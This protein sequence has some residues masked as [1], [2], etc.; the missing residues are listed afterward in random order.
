MIPVT[1]MLAYQWTVN[2]EKNTYLYLTGLSVVLAFIFKPLL[3]SIGFF[4]LN[5]VN[6]LHI[7]VAYMV[8][9][10]LSI[11]ITKG[12]LY[13]QKSQGKSTSSRFSL[14]KAG[15]KKEKAK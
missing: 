8:I 7:F 5:R 2:H 6:F 15:G 1:Y 10:L 4:Q 14:S 9:M 12:F 11:W 13:M 3:A